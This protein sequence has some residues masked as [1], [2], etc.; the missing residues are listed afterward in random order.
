MLNGRS[1]IYK[2]IEHF[3]RLDK[4][5][6]YLFLLSLLNIIGAALVKFKIGIFQDISLYLDKFWLMLLEQSIYPSLFFLMLSVFIKL[7]SKRQI[8]IGN[9]KVNEDPFDLIAKSNA[10][11]KKST[12]ELI[13]DVNDLISI[14]NRIIKFALL[15]IITFGPLSYFAN[16]GT[17]HFTGI[18]LFLIESLYYGFL[19]MLVGSVIVFLLYSVFRIY[20]G[21]ALKELKEK[22]LKEE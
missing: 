10:I 22:Q 9:E 2:E 19:T 3:T 20:W 6:N 21:L 15:F 1:K 14:Q 13:I 18:L 12:A 5:M 8:E 4:K 7:Y 16:L 17:E 11:S